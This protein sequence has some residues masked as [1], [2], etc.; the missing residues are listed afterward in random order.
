VKRKRQALPSVEEITTWYYENRP[1]WWTNL[2][3][4]PQEQWVSCGCS[5]RCWITQAIHDDI[6]RC[7]IV[8]DSL[9]GSA[10]PSNL[11]LLSP[12]M[13]DRGPNTDDPKI[14]TDWMKAEVRAVQHDRDNRME[15]ARIVFGVTKA[16][17]SVSAALAWCLSKND[18]LDGVISEMLGIKLG[19]HWR[20]SGEPTNMY[21][22][23]FSMLKRLMDVEGLWGQSVA[24]VCRRLDAK[25][26]TIKCMNGS[27]AILPLFGEAA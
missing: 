5:D 17:V 4:N 9:G 23:S 3:R 10:H 1:T 14:F 24:G 19:I 27:P 26:K 12:R 13:H 21:L 20:Q 18:Y 16:G 11:V 2:S 6:Q 8:P 7:H 25:W 15:A 22:E